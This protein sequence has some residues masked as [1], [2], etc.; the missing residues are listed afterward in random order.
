[1]KEETLLGLYKGAGPPL[2]FSVVY[3]SALFWSYAESKIF[4]KTLL[5]SLDDNNGDSSL[6]QLFLAGMLSGQV[7]CIVG[8]PI[9]LLKTK[10][11]QYRTHHASAMRAFREIWK[12]NKFRGLYQGFGAHLIRDSFSCVYFLGY[13]LGKKFLSEKPNLAPLLGGLLGGA[14]FWTLSFPFDVVKSRMQADAIQHS[15][16]NYPTVLSSIQTIYKLGGIKLFWTGYSAGMLRTCIISG[17]S[18]FVY[19]RI[20]QYLDFVI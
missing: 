2:L 11:Q 8:T 6:S 12:I 14:S 7:S 4:V 17:F 20:R 13:E 1:V 16:R 10:R 18:F 19:D 5:P 9:D 15:M 3:S